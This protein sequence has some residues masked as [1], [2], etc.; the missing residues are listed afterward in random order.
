M[1]KKFIVKCFILLIG[2]VG[3]SQNKIQ[4]TIFNKDQKVLAGSHIHI[5]SKTVSADTNGKYEI[6]N[7]PSGS[8]KV[9]VSFIGY[10]TIDTLVNVSDDLILD[11]VLKQKA[12]LLEEIVV[13]QKGNF[14]NQSVAEQKIKSETIEKYSNQTLGDALKEV[15]G[16]TLLKTGS[17]IVKPV[18]NGLHSSRVPVI[19]NNIRLEDQEWGAEHAPNFDI[20]AAGKITVIKGAS[21]LQFGGDAVGGIVIIE[22]M[23]V[24]KDTLFGKTLFNL[25]S[26]GRG[27]SI[28]TS[29]HKGNFCDWSWN[30][31]GTLKYLGDRET[32]NYVLSN[33]GNREANFSGDLKYTGKK[34]DIAA[35]Y[36]FYNAK[37]GILSASHIGNITDLYQSILNQVPYIS[38][39][40][41]YSLANPKQ[42]VQHHI[43]K[44][45]YNWHHTENTLWAF[46]YAF[47]FNKR[48]EFDVRRGSNSDKP[49]LDLELATH[50]VSADYKKT[51]QNWTVKSGW[52]GSYQNNFASPKT[53]VRPLIPSYSKIDSGIYGVAEYRLSNKLTLE[54]GI[55]YDFSTIEATKYYLKSR[56]DERNYSPEFDSFIVNAEGNQWLTKP[57]FTFHNVSASAGVHKEFQ[58]EWNGFGN[59]S[60]AV[61]NPN[62]SEFFSD[63][64]HHS[65][66]MIELGDLRLKKEQSFKISATLQKK[67]RAFSFDVTP[68]SNTIANY[69]FLKPVGFETS[70][71]GAFP[72]WEYQQTLARLIGIDIQTHWNIIKNWE[73]HSALS[74]VNGRDI[75]K[76]QPLIDIPPL[77][78]SQKIQ[79][80]KKEWQAM[81]LELRSEI[82]LGQNQFPNNNFNTNILVNGELTSVLVDISTPPAGYHLLHF[83]AEIKVNAFQKA[84]TKLAFSVQNIGNTTYRDYLN[85]QRFFAEEMGRNF[86]LQLKINY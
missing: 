19:N 22:P 41:T 79:F 65:T 10:E 34:Y 71:R 49:A 12:A 68:F 33:T 25:A 44:L 7:I 23:V 2:V 69:M 18:I 47:Q 5:G 30:A 11:F 64:L 52:N 17:T 9:F 24:K 48:L 82:V 6:K 85:R 36:S 32:P 20:N 53:G 50:S 73:L 80:S 8:L 1:Q 14:L 16:V 45:N 28:S 77:N 4:G 70:I 59:V 56:W 67:W 84:E 42:E 37:I 61:R 81:L 46:Q 66:G 60:L 78:L 57:Q 62:P 27:G 43:A 63:G 76:K 39:D 15:A 38:N 35:F 3:Y 51:G 54:S 83:Y 29:L 72:V 26:N 55:R 13:K 40:F 75:S 58:H 31:M 21:G 86:Q 74:Y